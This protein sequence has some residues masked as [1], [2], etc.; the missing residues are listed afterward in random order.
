VI[1]SKIAKDVFERMWAGEGRARAIVEKQGLQQVSDT[2][3]LDAIIDAL[4][5]ANPGQAAAVKDKPQ[6]L[7][8][9]V[10][11]VMKETGGKANPGAVNQL[12]RAKLGIG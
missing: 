3:A 12:L 8:W 10:G 5:A 1:S 6:A 11:Q 7:G 2:G 4:I 9:F